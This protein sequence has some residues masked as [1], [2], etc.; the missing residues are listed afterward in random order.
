MWRGISFVVFAIFL[1]LWAFYFQKSK[2]SMA[3]FFVG[4]IVVVISLN[5]AKYQAGYIS[6][7]VRPCLLCS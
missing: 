7:F 3:F 1:L 2:Y 5:F 4:I 6:P